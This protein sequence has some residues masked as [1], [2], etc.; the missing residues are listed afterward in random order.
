M[1]P[2]MGPG[3]HRAG[4]SRGIELAVQGTCHRVGNPGE[5]IILVATTYKRPS[6]ERGMRLNLWSPKMKLRSI[7]RDPKETG[8]IQSNKNFEQLSLSSVSLPSLEGNKE[9]EEL[10]SGQ[11]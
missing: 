11:L 2:R 7:N 3:T 6:W 10:S 8:L 4:A 5:A 9:D 1:W